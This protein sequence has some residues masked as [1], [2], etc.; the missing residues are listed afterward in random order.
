[1]TQKLV[2]NVDEDNR[3]SIINF[4]KEL[5]SQDRLTETALKIEYETVIRMLK[6]QIED[7][8][9][10]KQDQ[11]T[12]FVSTTQEN[13]KEIS[14]LRLKLALKQQFVDEFLGSFKEHVEDYRQAVRL[15]SMEKMKTLYQ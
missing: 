4:L 3:S 11:L 12:Q 2:E 7:L 13:Y 8:K 15:S 14:D 1:M 5:D 10:E 9:K 6:A